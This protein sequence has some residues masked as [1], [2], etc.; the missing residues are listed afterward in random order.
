MWQVETNTAITLSALNSHDTGVWLCRMIL[1]SLLETF[2]SAR[3]AIV[4]DVMSLYE[5]LPSSMRHVSLTLV[6]S[7][8]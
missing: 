3:S 5:I 4:V 6:H 7:N 2:W 8:K 1:L